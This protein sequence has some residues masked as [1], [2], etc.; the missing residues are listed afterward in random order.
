MGRSYFIVKLQFQLFLFT[1]LY[2]ILIMRSITYEERTAVSPFFCLP[3]Q[4]LSFLSLVGFIKSKF[5]RTRLYSVKW[6]RK[7]IVNVSRQRFE[8]S[9]SDHQKLS[10]YIQCVQ[11]QSFC[12]VCGLTM[13]LSTYHFASMCHWPYRPKHLVE[14]L[15]KNFQK[16]LKF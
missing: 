6:D 1:L 14:D 5:V 3:K 11:L 10:S 7:M 2:S 13:T 8:R 12:S 16:R 9:C 4:E 15:L